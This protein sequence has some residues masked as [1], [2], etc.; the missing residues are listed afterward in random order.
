MNKPKEQLVIIGAGGHAKVCYD[1]AKLMNQW[2]KII[3]LDDNPENDYFKIAGSIDDSSKYINGSEF[4]VAL[5]NNNTREKI[6]NEL[7]EL[8]ATIITLI[9]PNSIIASDVIID[10]GTVVMAGVVI[11]SATQIGK[12]CIINTSSSIDHDNTIKNYVH[13]SPG[14]TLSGTVKVGSK[15]WIGSGVVVSNNIEI[16]SDIIVGAGSVIVNNIKKR[17]TYYGVPARK[18]NDE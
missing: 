4:F 11:N 7:T 12:G 15:T 2:N 9:H 17:G 3:L 6:T 13:I 8:E 16:E 18:Q 1:I 10:E 14:V 5:G